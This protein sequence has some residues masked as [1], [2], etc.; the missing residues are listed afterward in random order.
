MTTF[1]VPPAGAPAWREIY[2]SPP[3]VQTGRWCPLD[4]TTLVIRLDGWSCPVC[5][6]AWDFHGLAGRWLSEVPAV[7]WRPST[8]LMLS[9][10]AGSAF[11]AA[12]VVMLADLLDQRLLWWLISAVAAATVLYAAVGWLSA[13]V[14]GW[15]YRHNRITAV[16][17]SPAQTHAGVEQALNGPEVCDEQ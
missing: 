2:Q 5:S 17:D 13:L 3:D 8:A 10:L 14:A 15:P 16:Y 12:G 11:A 7:R 1:A 9:I 6:A 4:D